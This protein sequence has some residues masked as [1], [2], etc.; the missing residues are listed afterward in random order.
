MSTEDVRVK[1]LLALAAQKFI[2]DIATDAM[3]YAKVR[4]QT[5]QRKGTASGDP[6]GKIASWSI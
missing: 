4:Q 2:S 1:R 6:K 5:A 3:Q